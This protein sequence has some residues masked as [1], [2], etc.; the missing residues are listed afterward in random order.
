MGRPTLGQVAEQLI[1]LARLSALDLT[2]KR[3]GVDLD[4][5]V[6]GPDRLRSTQLSLTVSPTVDT[7]FSP[8][9]CP[10][11]LRLVSCWSLHRNAH[12]PTGQVR[13]TSMNIQLALEKRLADLK[14]I[15][16]TNLA[17]SSAEAAYVESSEVRVSIIAG[18]KVPISFPGCLPPSSTIRYIRG[19]P[20][21][22][23]P[24]R[25][26]MGSSAQT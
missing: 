1:P 18:E 26:Y 17:L 23:Q 20:W 10:S 13:E 6:E 22:Q 7:N 4:L 14:Q 16:K 12:H 19:A 15:L 8:T 9:I 25:Q 11:N 5:A 3:R 2:S 21:S 24:Y